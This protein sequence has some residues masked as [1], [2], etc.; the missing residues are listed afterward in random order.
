M[1]EGL[2]WVFEIFDRLSAPGKAMADSMSS[3]ERTLKSVEER[4]FTVDQAIAKSKLAT[5]PAA[6]GRRRLP[7]GERGEPSEREHLRGHADLQRGR[8]ARGAALALLER[9]EPHR[10]RAPEDPEDGGASSSSR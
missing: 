6:R 3:V 9:C 10:V 2:S 7:A 8:D 5:L 1:S 4:L